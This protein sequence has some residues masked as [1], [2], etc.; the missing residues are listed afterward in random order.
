MLTVRDHTTTDLFGLVSHLS[1]PKRQAL[2]RSWAGVFR[3][4]L[5]KHLPTRELAAYFSGTHGR[6]SKDLYAVMGAF[7]LQQLHDLSDAATVEAYGFNQLW[8][9]ALNIRNEADAYLCERTLRHY[10]R[11]VIETGLDRQVFRVL[12]DKLVRAFGVDTRQQRLDSTAVRSCLRTLTRFGLVTE[13]LGKFIREVDRR[14]PRY[15]DWIPP[16]PRERYLESVTQSWSSQIT[17]RQARVSLEQAGQ[18]LG[19]LVEVFAPSKAK[20]LPS[21]PL[22]RRVLEEQF[23]VTS[24]AGTPA[25]LEVKAPELI[26]SDGVQNPADPDA[27]FNTRYG[28]GYGIQVMETYQVVT[29]PKARSKGRRAGLT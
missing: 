12:T 28:Q 29:E 26:P 14:C 27:S 4:P 6:P 24:A 2:E 21:Y 7:I 8:H 16:N 18:D 10:R 25:K 1:K 19:H 5:L 22:L 9:H 20:A 23:S 17:P 13:T 3:D 15:R 11:R